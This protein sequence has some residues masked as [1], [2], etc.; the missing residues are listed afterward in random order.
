[1]S[2]TVDDL[3]L[4]W[5]VWKDG[6]AELRSTRILSFVHAVYIAYAYRKQAAPSELVGPRSFLR[7][8]SVL[9]GRPVP[10]VLSNELLP[11]YAFGYLL[12]CQD[13]TDLVYTLLT[14]LQPL[15]TFLFDLSDA[16]IRA[17]TMAAAVEAFRAHPSKGAAESFLGH[18]LVGLISVTGGGIT[19]KWLKHQA[20]RY[21][22]WDFSVVALGTAGYV[23]VT[24]SAAVLKLM[25]SYVAPFLI[26]RSPQD[27]LV[28]YLANDAVPKIRQVGRVFGVP[29]SLS[30]EEWKYVVAAWILVGFLLRP[31]VTALFSARTPSVPKIAEAAGEAETKKDK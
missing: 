16:I 7:G 19:Y 30:A 3:A 10:W 11:T 18:F 20:F 12:V 17:F 6:V 15:P 9:T 2:Y 27:L 26:K 21:P 29:P 22:G 13:P 25:Q 14:A 28:T 5:P 23:Y 8:L 1:M 24:S 4:V 31:F